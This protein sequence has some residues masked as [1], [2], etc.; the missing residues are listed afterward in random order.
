M[1][2]S[3]RERD[4][5]KA[6]YVPDKYHDAFYSPRWRDGQYC[7]KCNRQHPNAMPKGGK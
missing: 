7:L 2:A 6:Y 5:D 4:M 3:K 1:N